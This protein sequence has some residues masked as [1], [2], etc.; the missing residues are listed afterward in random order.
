M[1]HE[2]VGVVEEEGADVRT[3][4]LGDVGSL[5]LWTKQLRE[6][7]LTLATAFAAPMSRD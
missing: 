1:S 4:K 3:V 7:S 5:S 6:R 2:A